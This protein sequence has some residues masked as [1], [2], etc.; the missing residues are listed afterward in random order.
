MGFLALREILTPIVILLYCKA[1]NN[2][3][4]VIQPAGVLR[5]GCDPF[6]LL[7]A[8]SNLNFAGTT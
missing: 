1:L 7:D 8:S 4:M 6:L 3:A 2:L 5:F